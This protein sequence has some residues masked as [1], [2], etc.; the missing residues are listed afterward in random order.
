MRLSQFSKEIKEKAKCG[1]FDINNMHTNT[2][3]LKMALILSKTCTKGN[4]NY[5]DAV[6]LP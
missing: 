5:S 3:K 1:I 2:T 4:A 6:L